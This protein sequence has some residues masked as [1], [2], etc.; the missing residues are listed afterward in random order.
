MDR[1][2]D[3]DRSTSQMERKTNM[4]TESKFYA[5][6]IVLALTALVVVP[7]LAATTII[8]TYTGQGFFFDGTTYNLRDERCGL[9]GQNDANDGGT[10]QFADWKNGEPYQTGQGYLVWVLSLNATPIDG[11]KLHLPDESV[12]MIQVGGTWKY[13]SQYYT[14]DTLVNHPVT[15]TFDDTGLKKSALKN[16]NLVV[17]HGCA[18]GEGGWCSPGFWKNAADG[19]WALTGY[20]KTDLFNETVV[21]D[22]YDTASAAD[23]TLIQVLTTPGANTFGAASGPYGLNAFN[24][25]GAFLTDQ[26]DGGFD[27]DQVGIEGA[28]QIDHFGVYK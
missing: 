14:R 10:G 23:P 19:A 7:V 1:F 26:L 21:P 3:P 25:T 12:D 20:E 5:L 17:S 16:V 6:V 27:P 28:C 24:A 8:V 11:V 18:P 15:V 9:T 13:A 4:K 22:F 2:G